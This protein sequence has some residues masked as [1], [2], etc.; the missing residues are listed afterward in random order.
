MRTLLVGLIAVLIGCGSSGDGGSPT[1]PSQQVPPASDFAG[2]YVLYTI[3]NFDG[4]TYDPLEV[5][6]LTLSPDGTWRTVDRA[7]VNTCMGFPSQYTDAGTHTGSWSVSDSAG[8]AHVNIN[9]LTFRMQDGPG[10]VY[11]DFTLTNTQPFTL[12]TQSGDTTLVTTLPPSS[13]ASQELEI[14]K[15][16]PPGGIL[17]DSDVIGVYALQTWNGKALPGF[18]SANVQ[19]KADTLAFGGTGIVTDSLWTCTGGQCI[20]NSPPVTVQVAAYP[21]TLT[22]STVTTGYGTST[23]LF[24]V[25]R[26]RSGQ[27]T[28]T[29]IVAGDSTLVYA[30][31][32]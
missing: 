13:Y 28:L 8:I 11:T 31:V 29:T 24:Q 2:T 30:K 5:A 32:P 20:T 15:K 16:L 1:G 17:D 27:L 19:E 6:R 10:V 21:W 3:G 22:D 4:F 14:W 12:D 23:Q 26:N 18:L 7:C 25:A 9:A